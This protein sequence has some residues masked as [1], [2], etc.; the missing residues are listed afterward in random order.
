MQGSQIK[1][2]DSFLNTL[3][4]LSPH[5]Q[6]AYRRDLNVLLGYC[7]DHD[8]KQWQELDGRRMRSFVAWRHRQGIG[9]KTLQRNLSAVRLFFQYLIKEGA[10]R[11]NPAV[12]IAAPKSARKLPRALDT[13]QAEQ[14]VTIKENDPLALRDH[15][16]LELMYSSGLRLSELTSL[17]TTAVDLEDAMLTVRG[18]GNKTRSVPVGRYAIRAIR[19]WLPVRK[20]MAATEQKALFISRR[21]NRL[22]PRSVQQRLRTW[23]I[24]QG[25]PGHVHPHMLR[26]SFAS[27]LLES[28]GDLR[29]V[30]ELLGHADISTTQVY[31]HLDFQHLAKVYDRAHPRAGR[32]KD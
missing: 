15:A 24:R 18:K 32:K 30:Q 31:T 25:L 19:E 6:S 12:G 11:Q 7:R 3:Q 28:S 21:G 5:T 14:L 13:E 9:G 4:H 29:A 8:V 27:H 2:V 22:G 23:A 1:L 16:M 26:H 17:D 10:A 20:T